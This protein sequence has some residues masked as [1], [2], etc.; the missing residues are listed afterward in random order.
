MLTEEQARRLS[1]L[2]TSDPNAKQWI[3][4]LLEERRQLL[5]IVQRLARHLH[6]LR[7]RT[8]AAARYLEALTAKAEAVA[9]EPWPG[10]LP[11][12]ECGAPAIG[13]SID[14]RPGR[15]HL[16]LVRHP[17]GR[18]CEA[19]DVGA[20]SPAAEQNRTKAR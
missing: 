2:R 13:S 12:P 10:Q 1:E 18:T 14:Y 16:R 8:S 5:A 17:D 9:R 3:D 6:H 7:R 11:C 15:G 19:Q 4:R 20:A